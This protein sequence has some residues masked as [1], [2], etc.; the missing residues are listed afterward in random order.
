M[1]DNCVICGNE[2]EIQRCCS[3][4]ECGCMGMPTEPPV[5][6]IECERRFFVAKD[7][8]L[9]RQEMKKDHPDGVKILKQYNI[10]KLNTIIMGINKAK[11]IIRIHELFPVDG[12]LSLSIQNCLIGTNNG[13]GGFRTNMGYE[14]YLF[15]KEEDDF[16]FNIKVHESG[17]IQA[18]ELI[19]RAYK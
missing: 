17:L 11:A 16:E 18:I 4:H 9:I 5:C 3:G 13:E 1:K 19:E 15:N 6:S 7:I 14:I 12:N 2:I 8:E 10:N